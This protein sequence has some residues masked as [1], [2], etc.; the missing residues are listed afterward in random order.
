MSDKA[1]QV[2]G[3]KKSITENNLTY[4]LFN[5]YLY[6]EAKVNIHLYEGM[7]IRRQHTDQSKLRILVDLI[8]NNEYKD[9]TSHLIYNSFHLST[10]E[11]K[12]GIWEDILEFREISKADIEKYREN[13]KSTCLN[14]LLFR[15]NSIND[16]EKKLEY[17]REHDYKDSFSTQI[18]VQTF[19]EA[20]DSDEDRLMSSGV[21]APLSF[22]D[23]ASPINEY[24]SGQL[25]AISAPPGCFTGDTRVR[26]YDG[27]SISFEELS[28]NISSGEYYTYSCDN[29]GN[30]VK[31]K[32]KD[33][34][35]T[36]ETADLVEVY[37]DNNTSVRCTPDHK[38]QL[39]DGSYK[40]AKDLLPGDS[41]MSDWRLNR[42]SLKDLY[43]RPEDYMNFL[44][45]KGH[46]IYLIKNEVTGKHYV[47]KNNSTLYHRFHKHHYYTG[48]FQMYNTLNDVGL[49]K[50]NHLYNSMRKYGLD[51]FSVRVL[52]Y[53]ELSNEKYYIEHY[54]SFENGYNRT[55]DGECI[56]SEYSQVGFKCMTRDGDLIRIPPEE[57][58]LYESDGWELGVPKWI[59][60][61]AQ[62]TRDLRGS[63]FSNFEVQSK[64]GKKG[65]R[66]GFERGT[67]VLSNPILRAEAARK[68]RESQKLN[69]TGIYDPEVIRRGH[70]T[71]SN[72]WK[73][74]ELK[75]S[76]LHE[77]HLKD[78]TRRAAEVQFEWGLKVMDKIISLGLAVTEK[79]YSD[80]RK[81]MDR[82]HSHI[83]TWDT[84][85]RKM[86]LDQ[87]IRYGID[88]HKVVKVE[89]IKLDSPIK[90]YDLEV[91]SE[92]HNFLLHNCEVYCHNCGKSLF[93]MHQAAI[94][95]NAG[96][97][98]LFSAFGDLKPSDFLTRIAAMVTEKPMREV[99]LELDDNIDQA[100][101]YLKG[102]LSISCSPSQKVTAK[103]YVNYCLDRKDDYDVFI[104]D[105]DANLAT[106]ADSMYE[107]GGKLYDYLTEIT[108][109]N[110]LVFVASQPKIHTWNQ[111]ILGLDSL[112]ESSRKQH[113]LDVVITISR[114]RGANHVGIMNIAKNRRGSLDSK[115]VILSSCGKFVE[116]SQEKYQQLNNNPNKLSYNELL[117][118][119]LVQTS[120]AVDQ[121][122][123]QLNSS[124][125]IVP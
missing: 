55:P 10:E 104:L 66:V 11:E 71:L 93:L 31:S 54:D 120:G 26:L 116:L 114:A 77:L 90:V 106:D 13:Y 23:R 24:I 110:K 1:S 25:L 4:S 83:S 59:S 125:I 87:K 98:V 112:N 100:K 50:Q 115:P 113:I 42:Y 62:R 124:K 17:L 109:L 43:D 27:T 69:R 48:H 82:N 65:A 39:R 19:E 89:V 99:Y 121:F 103:E 96:K 102:N 7:L 29:D 6:H 41:L 32:I 122:M 8:K 91:E 47:G 46:K 49:R 118:R 123:D 117:Y 84:M 94:A 3:K 51:K 12:N 79:T 111:E 85:N 119:N 33:C 80:Y 37:I 72:M 70:E 9:I 16:P 44:E 30:S 60:Q 95:A 18:R 15:S 5:P 56:N 35:V 86:T 53:D 20:A 78:V 81:S 38:F 14:E 105:Y 57:V 107:A 63:G 92:F 101:N 64:G 61:K 75:M 52:S 88:N 68:G 36:K 108:A 34:W 76:P 73:S 28:N 97:R 2:T 67:N 22:I 45:L 74:G 58:P 40:E 21:H